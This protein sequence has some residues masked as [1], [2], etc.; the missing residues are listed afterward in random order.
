MKSIDL[1]VHTTASDGT[2]SPSEAVRLAKDA[3]LSAIAITDHDT[4]SGFSEAAAAGS[5][6][7]VEVVPG[8]EI[9]TKYKGA[10][11]ILGYF[12][13]PESE[14]LKPVLEWV[15]NDRDERNEKMA[16]LMRADGLP[17]YY[18]E[19]KKRFGDIVG[20]P[21]FAELLVEFGV[22]RDIKDAFDKYVDKGKKYWLPRKFLSIE[23]SVEIVGEAGGV[24]VLAHPFQYRLED[25]ELRELIKLCIDHGLK[26]IECRYSGY[27]PEQTEYLENLAGEFDLFRTGGSD[28]HGEHKKSIAIGSGTGSLN[29][30]YEYLEE[31]RYAA[32]RV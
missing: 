29:V 14:S 12:I 13:N 30:P 3:G 23:R 10:L 9:S 6:S 4:V 24:A 16:E 28:F 1:H 5:E 21:H 8:I 26:G 7:G 31:L 27:T 15:V 11:H 20:R 2:S 18:E 17:V 19:M 25:S 22:A 32:G